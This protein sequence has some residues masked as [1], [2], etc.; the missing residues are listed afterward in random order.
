MYNDL[1]SSSINYPHN[2]DELIFLN[3]ILFFKSNNNTNIN[4]YYL[5]NASKS[6]LNRYSSWSGNIGKILHQN[7]YNI[8]Y[9]NEKSSR[10]NLMK[11]EN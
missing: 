6:V 5:L 1:Y 10:Y 11:T 9:I 8:N 2:L 3:K 7:V 4:F